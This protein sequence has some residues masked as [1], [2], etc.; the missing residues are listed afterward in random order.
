VAAGRPA[1]VDEDL[2][3]RLSDTV[4]DRLRKQGIRS[5]VS[6]PIIVENRL[7]GVVTVSSRRGPFPPDAADCPT[8]FTELPATAVGNAQSR[9]E[10]ASSRTRDRGRH[11]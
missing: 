2:W 7:W 4:T 6:S 8:D 10:L 11:G 1:R 9:T 3:D 5:M